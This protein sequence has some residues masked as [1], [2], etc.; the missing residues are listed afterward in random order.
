MDVARAGKKFAV[1]GDI[2]D[3]RPL[4]LATWRTE[5]AFREIRLREIKPGEAGQTKKPG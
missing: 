4:G 1:R 2:D 5:A 3:S